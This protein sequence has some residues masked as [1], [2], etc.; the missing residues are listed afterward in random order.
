[1]SWCRKHKRQGI[2]FGVR[3][4][5]QQRISFWS[6]TCCSATQ[7]DPPF[8]CDLRTL[9]SP[10]PTSGRMGCNFGLRRELSFDAEQT[11]TCTRRA[12]GTCETWKH[13]GVRHGG[14]MLG[15]RKPSHT[16][17]SPNKSDPELCNR[18]RDVSQRRLTDCKPM[19]SNGSQQEIEPAGDEGDADPKAERRRPQS[20]AYRH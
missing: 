12:V 2:E 6:Q 9:R 14:R 16:A 10:W 15:R 13:W 11:S 17:Q 20:Q 8:H 18:Q 19:A 4:G 1:M 5:L 3:A 7:D